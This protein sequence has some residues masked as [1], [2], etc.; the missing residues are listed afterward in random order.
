M[1]FI[2]SPNPLLFI[3][4]RR[5]SKPKKRQNS[6]NVLLHLTAKEKTIFVDLPNQLFKFKSSFTNFKLRCL[7]GLIKNRQVLLPVLLY[8]RVHSF[9]QP[10]FA[11]L[12]KETKI[13]QKPMSKYIINAECSKSP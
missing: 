2:H 9:V 12:Q 7:H 3:L 5:A 1:S 13:I 10:L 11:I 6:S 8:P 4:V